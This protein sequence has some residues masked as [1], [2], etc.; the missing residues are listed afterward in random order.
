MRTAYLIGRFLEKLIRQIVQ[1][2]GMQHG[3]GAQAR[4]ATKRMP[5]IAGGLSWRTAGTPSKFPKL[6]KRRSGHFQTLE[7]EVAE[8]TVSFFVLAANLA[9]PGG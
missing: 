4:D 3:D 8:V 7:L 9:A 1:G 5:R 6:G 2:L